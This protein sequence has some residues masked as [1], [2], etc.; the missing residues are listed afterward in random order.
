MPG[1]DGLEATTRPA[2]AAS[3][4]R[5][6]IVTTFDLDEYVFRAPRAGAGGFLL[7]AAPPGRLADAV[8]APGRAPR[9]TLRR[10]RG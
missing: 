1:L 5:V 8:G 7:K 10:P 6:L 4:A 3:R 9:P 2:A